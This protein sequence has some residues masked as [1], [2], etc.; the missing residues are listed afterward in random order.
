MSDL[1]LDT[2]LSDERLKWIACAVRN[3]GLNREEL[4]VV[5]RHELAPFLGSNQLNVA[6]VWTGFDPD[7]VCEE[8]Q[9]LRGKR[10][11]LDRLLS[12]LGLTTKTARATWNRVLEIA[13]DDETSSPL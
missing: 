3:S 10:R 7:W 1:W 9:K 5:F 4:E 6:G 12:T 2:E 11:I 13:F 8:A